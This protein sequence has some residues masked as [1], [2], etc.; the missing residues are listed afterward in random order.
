M[1]S[2]EHDFLN[3]AAQQV[4]RAAHDAALRLNHRE[5][6]TEHLLLGLLEVNDPIVTSILTHFDIAPK[7]LRK[8]IGFVV[9]RGRTPPAT[10]Q[11]SDLA[12]N[13][14]RGAWHEA[15]GLRSDTVRP[16]HL[17]LG[18]LCERQGLASG[19]L[20]SHRMTYD[21]TREQIA[22]V[23]MQGVQRTAYAIEHQLR[24]QMTP[25]LNMV[26]RDMTT[27]NLNI[28]RRAGLFNQFSQVFG[29]LATQDRFSI[30]SYPHQ[31]VLDV[32]HGMRTF[33]VFHGSHYSW[34]C[35]VCSRSG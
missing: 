23:Q 29:Y 10:A 13:V 15:R 1:M 17:L 27:H 21:R 34:I 35:L 20:E 14:L 26:S 24:F 9:G 22:Q 33:S 6:S 16:E 18:L 2:R 25:T 4:V 19:V 12:L 28:Q 3:P 5:I 8:D 31:V 11:M 7:Q 30:F 32:V